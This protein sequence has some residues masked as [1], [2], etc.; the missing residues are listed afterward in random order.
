MN[1]VF[2]SQKSH[3][4]C[5]YCNTDGTSNNDNDGDTASA[6]TGDNHKNSQMQK[7]I[8]ALFWLLWF[9]LAFKS[10]V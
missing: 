9:L 8:I 1:I 2:V 6:V 4:L 3:C 10:F 7:S 5:L